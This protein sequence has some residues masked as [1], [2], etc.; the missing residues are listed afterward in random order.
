MICCGRGTG[1]W[2]NGEELF[3]R[4]TSDGAVVDEQALAQWSTD[5]CF[6]VNGDRDRDGVP[7]VTL[8]GREDYSWDGYRSLM[9]MCSDVHVVG[10]IFSGT[11]HVGVTRPFWQPHYYF[12]IRDIY[13]TGCEFV[14]IDNGKSRFF[15]IG[16]GGMFGEGA[17]RKGD[18]CTYDLDG[19][20]IG[21]CSFLGTQFGVI[22]A[23]GDKDY[24][25]VKNLVFQGNRLVNGEVFLR[26]ED[27]HT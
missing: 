21:G 17:E 1:S 11:A 7:D 15:G 13:L 25:G 26:N 27:A 2:V 10:L 24:A 18:P 8:A 3:V 19:F 6:T 9:L 23:G 20:Y 5:G 14:A 16:G 4:Y 22:C 12:N